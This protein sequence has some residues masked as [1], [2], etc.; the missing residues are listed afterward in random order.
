MQQLLFDTPDGELTVNI[1][2]I[3]DLTP[4]ERVWRGLVTQR[5]QDLTIRSG[6]AYC[7]VYPGTKI[8]EYPPAN[9]D[10]SGRITYTGTGCDIPETVTHHVRSCIALTRLL[11]N[12]FPTLF[13]PDPLTARD[14]II[15]LF[16]HHDG[17]EPFSG[18]APDDGSQ[19]KR[20]K[21]YRELQT[22]IR[23]IAYLSDSNLKARLIKAFVHFQY[24]TPPHALYRGWTAQERD[25][26]QLTRLI[27]KADAVFSTLL[28]ERT[29]HAGRLAYKAHHYGNVTDDDAHYIELCG[30]DRIADTW[31]AHFLYS[32][33]S[34]YGFREILSVLHAAVLEVRGTWYPWWDDVCK[35]YGINPILPD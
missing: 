27:D 29:G 11:S 30:T 23:N 25:T 33:H 32:Y 12:E 19:D 7:G 9:Y 21:N 14:N 1:P 4:A 35:V 6:V 22:F 16:E 26:A 8:P 3:A 31:A 5:L 17:D 28:A 20:T 13:A 10:A 15:S 24:C 18:D 34:Y 2:E